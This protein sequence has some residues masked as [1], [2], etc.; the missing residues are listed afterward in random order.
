MLRRFDAPDSDSVS[1]EYPTCKKRRTR[2]ESSSGSCSANSRSRASSESNS[3]D[4]IR[5]VVQPAG[6]LLSQL[7]AMNEGNTTDGDK[8]VFAQQAQK[9]SRIKAVL[10]EKCCKKNCKKNLTWRLVLNMVTFFWALPKVSQDC[11]LWSIQQRT[12][13]IGDPNETDSDSE[14]SESDSPK[15]KISWSIEGRGFKTLVKI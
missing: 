2:S 8:S 7:V 9:P 6:L 11:V 10:Q 15:H 1:S 4:E 3:D 12:L 13:S 14:H 5:E